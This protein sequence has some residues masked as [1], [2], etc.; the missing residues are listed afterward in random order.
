MSLSS[1]IHGIQ[2]AVEEGEG[3]FFY[4]CSRDTNFPLHHGKL[5]PVYRWMMV[6]LFLQCTF[7]TTVEIC[8]PVSGI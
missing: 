1:L 4:T 7:R 6:G 8:P 3:G 5:Y 2:F